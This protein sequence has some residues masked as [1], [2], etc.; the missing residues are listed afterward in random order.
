MGRLLKEF[1]AKGWLKHGGTID[2]Q[3]IQRYKEYI[4]K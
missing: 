4:N 1:K 3:R 2:K